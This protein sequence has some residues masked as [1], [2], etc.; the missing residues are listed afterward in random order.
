ML[1]LSTKNSNHVEKVPKTKVLTES[2]PSRASSP[3]AFR[4]GTP[5]FDNEGAAVQSRSRRLTY[6]EAIRSYSAKRKG[7]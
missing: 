3:P 1:G 4:C 6:G 7:N 5:I 2:V